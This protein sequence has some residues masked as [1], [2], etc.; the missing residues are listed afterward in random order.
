MTRYSVT[1]GRFT[2]TDFFDNNRYTH[3][4]RTQ[5]MAGP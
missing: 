4:P 3:E 5:F 2:M 1:I